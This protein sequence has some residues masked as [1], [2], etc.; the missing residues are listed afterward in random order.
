MIG[1]IGNIY[2][3]PNCIDC[4]QLKFDSEDNDYILFMSRLEYKKG[5]EQFLSALHILQNNSISFPSV[6]IAGAGKA[7]YIDRVKKQICDL[8]LNER[9]T[10]LGRVDG[11]EKM[12]LLCKASLFVL[13]TFSENFGIV[14][15]EALY[16]G[17]PVLT[18]VQS[19][20]VDLDLRGI[21]YSLPSNEPKLLGVYIAEH[22]ALSK[23]EMQ[24]MRKKAHEYIVENFLC[25]NILTDF[26]KLFDT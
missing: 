11:E 3:I 22:F 8:G 9:V 16:S 1:K 2:L 17:V 4:E 20:W 12:N 26:I 15:A 13:P 23:S 14:I 24:L 25:E 6:Y 7:D 19:S 10:M 18:T 21:G 5:V